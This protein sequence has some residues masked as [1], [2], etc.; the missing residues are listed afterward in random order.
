MCLTNVASVGTAVI[1][2][3]NVYFPSLAETIKQNSTIQA[4]AF[5][6]KLHYMNKEREVILDEREVNERP[7]LEKKVVCIVSRSERT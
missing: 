2:S 3:I 1:I 7:S 4:K 6:R 5:C